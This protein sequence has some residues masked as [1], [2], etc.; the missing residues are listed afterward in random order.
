MPLKFR[1]A[2]DFNET[3]FTCAEA[4]AEKA[5]CPRASV[6]CVIVDLDGFIRVTGY[7]GAPARM[8]T[9]NQLG[10]LIEGGH[11]V[12]A[13]HAEIRAITFAARH[14]I[15][16]DGCTAYSTLLP[17]IQCMQALREAGVRTIHYDKSYDREEREHLFRLAV[18]GSVLMQERIR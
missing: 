5:T 2:R 7:N 1:S 18:A 15:G 11:C 3:Y 6:G 10:C 16:L 8:G 9:C 4:E 12:R 13:V 14:G 17:C